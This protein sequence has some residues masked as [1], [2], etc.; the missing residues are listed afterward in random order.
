MFF[1]PSITETQV[2]TALRLFLLS[3]LPAGIEVVRAEYN[4][5][6]EPKVADFVVMTA[7]SRNRLATNIDD[8]EDVRFTGSIAG[9][10]LTVDSV[11]YGTIQIG[12]TV[13]GATVAA[14]TSIISQ[15]TGSPSGGVG[16]YTVSPTQ[17]AA[18]QLLSCGHNDITQS[19]QFDM[20][21]DVH[22]P[23]SGNNAQTI[24]TLFRD[25]YAA[26]IFSTNGY[27]N[28]APLYCDDPKQMPFINAEQQY[29]LR[30]VVSAIMQANPIISVSQ[31]F[32]TLL[33][34][35]TIHDVL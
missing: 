30:W 23:N 11:A 31:Q 2:F 16:T 24:T 35:T 9:T 14:N 6:P 22:G 32:A 34:P 25:A 4:R 3:I 13:F 15:L 27:S 26:A 7:T 21:L 5:V 1:V 17:T 28:I 18:H 10:T 33:G 20:Q 8:Y 29:E 19:T 12:E